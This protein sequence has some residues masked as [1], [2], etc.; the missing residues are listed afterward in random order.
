MILAA[1]VAGLLC[2]LWIVPDS[3]AQAEG[4][5]AHDEVRVERM[6]AIAEILSTPIEDEGARAATLRRLVALQ[7]PA[8]AELFAVLEQEGLAAGFHPA[9]GRAPLDGPRLA[10]VRAALLSIPR[11]ALF[12]HLLLISRGS[13]RSGV[14]RTALDLLAEAGTE[15]ELALVL[16]FGRPLESERRLFGADLRAF[17][18]SL[19]RFLLR[20]QAALRSLPGALAALSRFER[21]P[22][23][24]AAA[25]TNTQ[26][27]MEALTEMFRIA[28]EI[29]ALVLSSLGRMARSV[30]HPISEQVRAC[31]R[32]FFSS[33][34]VL[35]VQEAILAAGELEDC[36]AVPALL[37]LLESGDGSLREVA[38]QALREITRLSLGPDSGPWRDWYEAEMDWWSSE[39]EE[40]LSDLTS[41]A[42]AAAA[43]AIVGIAHRKLFRH[44]LARALVGCLA[45]PEAGLV[46]LSC[47][48]L[49]EMRSASAVE[50]L[51]DSLEHED[52]SIRHEAWMTLRRITNRDLPPDPSAWR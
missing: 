26:R 35:L 8:A 41:G 23:V 18:E 34:H 13:L 38:G 45:R 9:E 29:D 30:P 46:R 50:A 10:C 25:A 2:A 24:R 27:A 21:A 16:A 42:P 3:S 4:P 14:R 51:V 49:G 6:A 33:S 39:S 28:P 11:P 37:D 36:E 17:E 5:G 7:P 1:R 40:L 31:V 48:A 43:K 52:A 15:R 22:V 19:R 47:R 32:G 12:D 44:E 20:N